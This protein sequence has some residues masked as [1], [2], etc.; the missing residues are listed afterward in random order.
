MNNYKCKCNNLGSPSCINKYCK[1]CCNGINCSIHSYKLRGCECKKEF[2]NNLCIDKKCK[3]CCNNIKCDVHFI[4]CK[5]KNGIIKKD[6]CNTDSCSGKCCNDSDC[7]Y[8]F[9]TG[10]EMVDKDFTYCKIVLGSKHV[11][12]TN[13]IN[14]IVDEYLDNRLKCI[15]CEYKFAD[16]ESDIDYGFARLCFICN[17]WVCENCSSTKIIY[18]TNES[19]C[20]FCEYC[21]S[22]MESDSDSSESDSDISED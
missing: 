19:F 10:H 12:P 20:S 6:T 21:Y 9:D 4:L 16:I 13:L 3:R 14:I 15:V 7:T 22:E 2:F 5:C 17:K 11:L 1:N 18:A 8:H